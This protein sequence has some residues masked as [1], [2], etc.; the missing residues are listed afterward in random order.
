MNLRP[1]RLLIALRMQAGQ[2]MAE[3]ATVLAVVTIAVVIT[4]ALVDKAMVKDLK[5]VN[6][7]IKGL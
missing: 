3:Y 5:Q 1:S 2:T 4:L 6:K 7:A